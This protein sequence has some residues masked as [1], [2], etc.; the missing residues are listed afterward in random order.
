MLC[1]GKVVNGLRRGCVERE[2][3]PRTAAHEP[4]TALSHHPHTCNACRIDHKSTHKG[5]I[6]KSGEATQATHEED[7]L[8]AKQCGQAVQDKRKKK[9]RNKWMQFV[10]R[11]FPWMDDKGRKRRHYTAQ[12][13][14]KQHS[15]FCK[16]SI[17]Y[18]IWNCLRNWIPSY[19][20][21]TNKAANCRFPMPFSVIVKGGS[22]SKYN[23]CQTT[24]TEKKPMLQIS[25]IDGWNARQ[26]APRQCQG[27]CGAKTG[28]RNPKVGPKKARKCKMCN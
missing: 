16:F 25:N 18:F 4:P 15:L 23:N 5:T 21:E 12:K 13:K 2:C 27:G 17:Y 7:A 22:I 9:H 6:T 10:L 26:G 28:E 24:I 8:R 1:K 19:C 20:R 11:N 14:I 3:A